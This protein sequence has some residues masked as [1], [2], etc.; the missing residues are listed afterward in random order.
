MEEKRVKIRKPKKSKKF[1]ELGE[2]EI[3]RKSEVVNSPESAKKPEIAKKPE[4]QKIEGS[5]KPGKVKFQRKWLIFLII[6]V[7]GFLA[8][9]GCL[10]FSFLRPK[11]EAEALV[12]PAIPSVKEA[13]STYSLLTGEALANADLKDAPTFCIQVPNGTDG[14]R[15]QSGLTEAGVIFEAI[16]EAGITRFAA[17][18]QN[19]SSA[20]IGPIR[21]LR[22]YFLE[23]DIPFGCT[24]VHAGGADDA[25]AMLRAGGYRDLDE[26]LQNMYRGTYGARRWN[27]LFTTGK[28]LKDFNQS[29]SYDKSDIKGFK[30]L[31]PEESEK[32]RAENLAEEKLDITKPTDK[33]TSMLAA[34]V[35]KITLKMGGWASYNPVYIYNPETN[36]YLR[37]Y[38]S[39]AAHEVY[40]CSDEDLGRKNPEDVCSLTQLNPS[41]VVAIMVPEKKAADNYHEIITTIGS[42]DAYI[43][44]NGVAIKGHWSKSTRNDQI[45]FLDGEGGEISLAPG[46][47]IVTAV[48]NYGRVEY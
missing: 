24:V 36:T 14:A 5:K 46:Q 41:V 26:N 12:F 19:P 10:L 1:E 33:D 4:E 48:P 22:T 18:Y 27:N 34:K 6:G 47:T 42:G 37:S 2:I 28:F 32:D 16:A 15:P 39:G 9:I 40:K 38:E 43:F 29:R 45:K 20:V 30:R 21:S 25:I 23:W 31:T 11:E 7:V 17:I 3:V 44:Q 13:E 35:G 8:G